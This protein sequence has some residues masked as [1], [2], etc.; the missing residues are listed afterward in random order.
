MLIAWALLAPVQARAAERM[1]VELRERF[2][3][4]SLVA[5]SLAKTNDGA[6]WF[7]TEAGLYRYDGA[8]YRRI[9]P[10]LLPA[11]ERVV[12][13]GD[14]VVAW[15]HGQP[16]VWL[17]GADARLLDPPVTAPVL[18]FE[19]D[20]D[21]LWVLAGN[22]LVRFD[23]EWATVET[24]GPISSLDADAQG[25][26]GL[27]DGRVWALSRGGIELL[28]EGIAS[29]THAARGPGALFV[30]ELYGPVWRVRDGARTR[31]VELEGR[32]AGLVEHGGVM[33][34]TS[35]HNLARLG[36]GDPVVTQIKSGPAAFDREGT[37]WMA[38]LTG[39]VEI[40]APDSVIYTVDDG[41]P[42]NAVLSATMLDDTLWVT[43]WHGL[44]RY[45]S[46]R[47]GFE[48]RPGLALAPVHG[49]D[50]EDANSTWALVVEDDAGA[51]DI[52]RG[53][54]CLRSGGWAWMLRDDGLVAL[55]TD[56][57]RVLSIPGGAPRMVEGR[58]GRVWLGYGDGRLCH[59]PADPDETSDW[60]CEQTTIS[61]PFTALWVAASGRVWVGTWHGGVWERT[62]SG[63]EPLAQQLPI[64]RVIS[65]RPSPRGG[66]WISGAGGP[67]RIEESDEGWTIRETI[68]TY[69]GLARSSP[70]DVFETADGD[71]WIATSEGVV[72][73]PV[74]VRDTPVA[75]ARPQWT[76]NGDEMSTRTRLTHA[77]RGGPIA[78]EFTAHSLRDPFG[79][80]YRF[81]LGPRMP[82]SEPRS[83]P[84][85]VLAG[86]A[87]GDYDVMLQAK[88]VG[89]E[90]V[91]A[92]DPVRITI[93]PPWYMTW[94]FRLVLIG[95]A[96]VVLLML[97]RLRVATALRLFAQ[98]S[99]IAADLHDEVGS[100]LSA[101]RITA[102][103]AA[104][105]PLPTEQATPM[106]EHI[107]D[108]SA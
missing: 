80:R 79:A 94:W 15:G 69:H 85:L 48:T 32:G 97:H 65:M 76:G 44:A 39:P 40:P 93:L 55:R 27:G 18:A 84:R 72:Q 57:R 29:A 25:I 83:E 37:L 11:A 14:G 60:S 61:H 107:A 17:E 68:R 2:A 7:A 74:G 22:E 90:W 66:V 91:S 73:I 26:L 102:S 46:A 52:D 28:A 33:W 54:P 49:V 95:A 62:E 50:C 71:L 38:T 36:P 78:L 56:M 75:L 70:G 87:P 58:G 34:G 4:A 64:R 105:Q 88:I 10:E 100:T 51:L 9:L 86:M 59:R 3:E 45:D 81:R 104:S 23:G 53:H 101:I 13:Y 5:W 42:S 24:P 41:L 43:T 96:M 92:Q 108:T 8:R 20:G 19:A 67:L 99:R 82:W 16:L 1:T 63:W 106:F 31:V 103:T 6:M 47:R 30:Q 35:S 98:R 77:A 89:T 12:E 21:D